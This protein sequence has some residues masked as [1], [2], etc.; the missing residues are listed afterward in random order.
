MHGALCSVDR[1]TSSPAVRAGAGEIVRQTKLLIWTGAIMATFT[2]LVLHRFNALTSEKL[3]GLHELRFRLA[4][5][6][7]VFNNWNNRRP[8]EPIT[9]TDWEV[10]RLNSR[11][12]SF[13]DY[14]TLLT[15]L[16][17]L[18]F[19][20]RHWTRLCTMKAVRN[21]TRTKRCR[22]RNGRNV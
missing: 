2:D 10:E 18:N 5:E 6:Q 11:P 22:P 4:D 1:P 13:P 19:K 8:S 21:D 20:A 15:A 16:E 17:R 3:K 7:Q 12:E 9:F 14:L